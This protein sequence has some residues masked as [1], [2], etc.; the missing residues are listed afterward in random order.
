MFL[1]CV[2]ICVYVELLW[3]VPFFFY[4]ETISIIFP[5]DATTC[6]TAK[7]NRNVRH[8]EYG[9]KSIVKGNLVTGNHPFVLTL[10]IR[11]RNTQMICFRRFKSPEMNLIH[12]DSFTKSGSFFITVI[13]G[14]FLSIR[15]LFAYSNDFI[16]NYSI[17][18]P[19]LPFILFFILPRSIVSRFYQT[20]IKDILCCWVYVVV[21]T[22]YVYVFSWDRFHCKKY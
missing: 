10:A 19:L 15:L 5:L 22:S 2:H 17:T 13:F 21:V 20:F 9:L 16:C 8:F 11:A 3:C 14:F 12:E 6:L 7:G 4:F 18:K 1:L